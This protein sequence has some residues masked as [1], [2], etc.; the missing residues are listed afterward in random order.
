M[1]TPQQDGMEPVSMRRLAGAVIAS[2]V[3]T[4]IEWYDFFLYG[5]AAALVL[6]TLFFPKQGPFVAPIIC[7]WQLSETARKDISDAD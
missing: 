7:V 4:T 2:T 5:S 3:G 6:P 1:K